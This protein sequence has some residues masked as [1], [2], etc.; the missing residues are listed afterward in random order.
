MVEM[1]RWIFELYM[2]PYAEE[3]H[4]P[5][6]H[7]LATRRAHGGNEVPVAVSSESVWGGARAFLVGFD[8]KTAPG[9]RL[10]GQTEQERRQNIEHI[11]QFFSLLFLQVRRYVY[12]HS[13]FHD[14][15][16]AIRK[17]PK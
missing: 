1:A 13:S 2:V 7:V 3:P 12:F 16:D 5:I 9:R 11:D 15:V 4:V 8:A 10:L 14:S 17:G 6:L